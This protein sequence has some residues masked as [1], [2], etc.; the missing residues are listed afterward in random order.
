M[1]LQLDERFAA[2]SQIPA[3]V[4]TGVDGARTSGATEEA[5]V[6]D[7]L[8]AGA[9]GLPVVACGDAVDEVWPIMGTGRRRVAKERKRID[10]ENLRC[11]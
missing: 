10:M 7:L 5:T 1:V 4:M 9:E 8:T 6:A 3:T 2:L 11:G